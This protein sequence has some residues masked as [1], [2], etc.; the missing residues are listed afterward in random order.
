[1][2][3][4]IWAAPITDVQVEAKQEGITLFFSDGCSNWCHKAFFHAKFTST[5]F[6]LLQKNVFTFQLLKLS[7]ARVHNAV[8]ANT[9]P[10]TSKTC[11]S[12]TFCWT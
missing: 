11:F 10:V 12:W 7:V 6:E 1:M 5:P 3:R 4:P 2:I 9:T 8:I